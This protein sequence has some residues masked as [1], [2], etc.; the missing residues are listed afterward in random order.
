M[1]EQQATVPQLEFVEASDEMVEMVD[2]MGAMTNDLKKAKA[3]V[4]KY[5]K[6][7]KSVTALA[8]ETVAPDQATAVIG[9][10]YVAQITEQR[11]QRDVINKAAIFEAVG[12]DTFVDIAQFKMTDLDKY[13]TPHQLEKVVAAVNAGPRRL[14]VTKRD[15][16]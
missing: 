12:N 4:A 6:L 11:M 13:L 5:E 16:A 14:T 8:S 1:T 2:Q 10:K 9:E 3:V 15:D 7:R